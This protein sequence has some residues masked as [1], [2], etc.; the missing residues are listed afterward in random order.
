MIKYFEDKASEKLVIKSWIELHGVNWDAPYH[1]EGCRK[2]IKLRNLLREKNF[3]EDVCD[4]PAWDAKIGSSND[5]YFYRVM[6][7][8]LK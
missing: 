1:A 5:S 2:G 6:H 3:T 4:I 7:Q 8:V